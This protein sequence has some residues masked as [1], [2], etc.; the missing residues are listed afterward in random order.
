MWNL[1]NKRILITG[2]T[3]GIGRAAVIETLKL[4]ATV[5]FTARNK[6]EIFAFEQELKEVQLPA[7]GLVSDIANAHDRSKVTSWVQQNWN[8]LDVIV[9]NAGINIRK[10]T[11]DYASDEY[12]KIFNV[13]LFAPFEISRGLVPHAC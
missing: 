8:A 1:N 13:N 5:L 6:E 3:K 12:Q 11:L 2:G 7:T 9:N 10:I 4:G